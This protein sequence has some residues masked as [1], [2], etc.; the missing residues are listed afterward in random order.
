MKII[1]PI[2]LSL[3][4]WPSVY[5][6]QYNE[7]KDSLSTTGLNEVVVEAQMQKTTSRVSVYIPTERQ[8]NAANDA[9]SLLN[10][11]SIPQLSI[12]LITNAVKST[13]GQPVSIFIDCTEASPE[14][15]S[16]LKP[17][18]VKRVDYHLNPS[19]PRFLG[20]KHV[21]NFVMHKY[22][23]GGYTRVDAA[24]SFCVPSTHASVYSKM[25][26]KSMSYA[27]FAGEQYNITRNDV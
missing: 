12:N 21:V 1:L 25:K 13:S 8:K 16:G 10:L 4:I 22:K 7:V 19:D 27:I 15:I 11:M 5:A 6:R 23:W 14:D 20:K 24:Q 26:Y 3:P 18:D 2:F 9:T 17:G